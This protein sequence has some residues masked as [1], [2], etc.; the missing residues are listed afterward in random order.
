MIKFSHLNFNKMQKDFPKLIVESILNEVARA[1]AKFPAWPTDMIHASAIVNEE[2]GELTKAAL[3]W[4]YEG[5]D[6][7]EAQKEAVQTAAMCLRFLRA[8]A[9]LQYTPQA[10]F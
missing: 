1:E 7:I 8:L 10:S 3:Q 4:T 2:A 6:I 5:G 9:E